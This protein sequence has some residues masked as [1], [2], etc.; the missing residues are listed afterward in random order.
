MPPTS[1]LLEIRNLGVDFTTERGA[2]R[3]VAGVSLDVQP[4]ECVAVVGESGSGKT[5][6]LLACLGLLADNGRA[7]GSVKFAARELIGAS[8]RELDSVRGVGMAL[9]SQ[10]P[11]SALTPHLR[12]ETPRRVRAHSNYS[13]RLRFP[14]R[15]GACSSIHTNFPAVCV[16]AWR[17]RS[18]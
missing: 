7:S 14:N 2:V 11:L 1:S 16:S 18:P 17:W 13:T 10:D 9:L 5:Q 12:I 4:G 3:A 6:L 8:E 15:P